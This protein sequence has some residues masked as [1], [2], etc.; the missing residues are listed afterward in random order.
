MGLGRTSS[1]P[2]NTIDVELRTSPLYAIR[3][4]TAD[5]SSFGYGQIGYSHVAALRGHQL[6]SEPECFASDEMPSLR[7]TL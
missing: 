6:A 3:S 1:L 2:L 5:K 7:T 4:T